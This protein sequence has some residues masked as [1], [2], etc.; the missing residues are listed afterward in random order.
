LKS[1]SWRLKRNTEKRRKE[2]GRRL[3]EA[4]KSAGLRQGWVG[5]ALGYRDKQADIS[6]IE[7]GKRLPDVVEL[8]NFAQLYGTSFDWFATWETQ[9][10]SDRQKFGFGNDVGL[11]EGEFQQR[12]EKIKERR[13]RWKHYKKKPIAGAAKKQPKQSVGAVS[14]VEAPKAGVKAEKQTTEHAGK[15]RAEGIRLFQLA[16]KPT[17]EQ[18]QLVYGERGHKMTWE[19]RAADGVPAEKFQEALKAKRQAKQAAVTQAA[20]S[21]VT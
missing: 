14:L 16:G 10:K 13:A 19:Q 3:Q 4:R 17:K 6:R 5:E 2:V 8:E 1:F 7:A 12:I 15:A 20:T 9:L 21:K 18:F 11:I